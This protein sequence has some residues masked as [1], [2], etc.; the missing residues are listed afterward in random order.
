VAA[1][2]SGRPAVRIDSPRLC[3]RHRP[4]LWAVSGPARALIAVVQ[5]IST[6][7]VRRLEITVTQ[8]LARYVLV[9]Y[10]LMVVVALVAPSGSLGIAIVAIGSLGSNSPYLLQN[11]FW[12]LAAIATLTLV[13]P[14]VIY[15]LSAGPV[16]IGAGSA[17]AR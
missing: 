16:V 11:W 1:P 14:A 7:V 3:A 5:L 12:G 8:E 6:I 4:S 10:L 13:A 15:G 2:R 9:E 17:A